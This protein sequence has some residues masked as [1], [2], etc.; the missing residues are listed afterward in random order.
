MQPEAR[1]RWSLRRRIIVGLLGY[2]VL[3]SAAVVVHGHVV[4]ERAEHLVWESLLHAELDHFVQRR[5]SDPAYEWPGTETLELFT[6]RKGLP[7]ALQDLA[8][9]VHDEI[10]VGDR[11]RVLLVRDEGGERLVLAL[12]IGELEEREQHLGLLMLASSLALILLLLVAAAWAVG[13]LMRPLR[14]LADRIAA[15]QP[16]LGG[17]R[18]ALPPDAGEELAVIAD[19]TNAFL[20]R[21]ERFVERERTFIDTASHELRT[22]VSIIAGAAE[23]ALNDPA[24]TATARTQL[25]RIR[26]TAREVETLISVLLVLAKEPARLADISEP[27]ALDQWVPRIVDDHRHLCRDKALTLRLGEAVPCVTVAPPHMVQVAIGNL[28]RNAIEHSDNGEIFVAWDA[29]GTVTIEDPGHGMTPEE[30]SALYVRMARG[31]ER[32]GGI[33]LAL[34]A[35]LCEHL[36]WR[37]EVASHVGNGSRMTLRFAAV[38]VT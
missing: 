5:R 34:I 14:A 18:V 16:Q 28:L 27:V 33:G 23:N 2:L 25:V 36:G 26:Q 20:E 31:G 12:D 19:A 9:G 15:L 7:A 24:V 11:E 10:F 8:P 37:L 35:R 3:L 1:R 17:E 22:P 4:N 21:S 13:R 30:I 38:A 6:S 32:G 29:S